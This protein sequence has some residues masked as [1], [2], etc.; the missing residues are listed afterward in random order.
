MYNMEKKIMDKTHNY[1]TL[2]T[3]RGWGAWAKKWI[4][5]NLSILDNRY[6]ICFKCDNMDSYNNYEVYPFS[7]GI[8]TGIDDIDSNPIFSSLVID[9]K[10]TK[11]GDIIEPPRIIYKNKRYEHGCITYGYSGELPKLRVYEKE[12]KFQVKNEEVLLNKCK[13]I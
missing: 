10:M 1:Q 13:I 12:G 2:T 8:Y 7:I 11:G 6:F 4:Y 9:G 5:G 3:F